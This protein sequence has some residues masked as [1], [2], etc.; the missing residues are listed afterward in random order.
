MPGRWEMCLRRQIRIFA[1]MIAVLGLSACGAAVNEPIAHSGSAVVKG[2][3]PSVVY[4]KI[5]RLVRMCWFKPSA[6]VLSKHIFYAKA[7]A[8][9]GSASIIIFEKSSQK[10][11]GLQA[12]SIE[13]NK[14]IK[15]TQNRTD[16]QTVAVCLGSKTL[17]RCK[18][19]GHR[20]MKAVSRSPKALVVPAP[21]HVRASARPWGVLANS[22]PT[23]RDGGL[24][25]FSSCRRST[26]CF[27]RR[28]RL[29]TATERIKL[30]GRTRL[31]RP[32]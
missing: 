5:A 26:G 13:F 15:A 10:K 3:Q 12:Y 14:R 1:A 16:K 8:D 17:C 24:I 21:D 30:F 31:E 28:L 11:R 19:A 6:P 25:G 29:E 7:P 27:H 2:E 22:T 4:A 23:S 18:P 9:G 32:S 20:G